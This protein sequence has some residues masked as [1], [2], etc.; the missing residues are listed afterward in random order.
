[1]ARETI[2][3]IGAG[4]TVFCLW[5]TAILFA[6]PI[7][8]A[9]RP[10]EGVVVALARPP[11][12]LV[13]SPPKLI[14]C[15]SDCPALLHRVEA[16]YP[17]ERGVRIRGAVRLRAVIG[18]DGRIRELHVLSGHPLLIPAAMDAVKQWMFAPTLVNGEPVEVESCI[19]IIFHPK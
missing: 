3:A 2:L 4:C 11:R 7:R 17:S 5:M 12:H 10:R 18:T 1:M 15:F 8:P 6:S 19:E 13:W 9:L 14:I 16:A